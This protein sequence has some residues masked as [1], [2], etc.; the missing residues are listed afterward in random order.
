LD[1]FV[2]SW[3]DYQQAIIPLNDLLEEHGQAILKAVAPINMA[4]MKDSEGTIW[5]IPRQGVMAHTAP[6]WFRTDWLAEAG[7]S[8]PQTLEDTEE[9]MAAFKELNPDAM[10]VSQLNMLRLATVG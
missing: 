2:Q 1:L 7:L 6:T 5:G 9:A 8:L 4:G 3:P 10:I